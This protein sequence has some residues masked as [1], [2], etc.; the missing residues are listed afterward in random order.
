MSVPVQVSRLLTHAGLPAFANTW[1]RGPPTA[2]LKAAERAIELA[3]PMAHGGPMI[4]PPRLRETFGDAAVY[5]EPTD[6]PQVVAA[7]VRG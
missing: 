5:A 4:L 3:W 6:V 2:V 7:P 1:S